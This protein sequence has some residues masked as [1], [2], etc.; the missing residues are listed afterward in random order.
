VNLNIEDQVPDY[1]IN[2]VAHALAY[3]Y[4][5]GWKQYAELMGETRGMLPKQWADANAHMFT[6]EAIEAISIKN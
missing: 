2:S 1:L 4:Y 6:Q 3:A 5:C